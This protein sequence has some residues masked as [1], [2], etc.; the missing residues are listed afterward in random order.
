MWHSGLLPESL[1][2][3]LSIRHRLIGAH[4]SI[5]ARSSKQH[6]RE[7]AT[8][9][10][11]VILSLTSHGDRIKSAHIAIETL[12]RQT[13]A[14]ERVILWISDRHSISGL[15]SPL[16]RQMRRGLDVRLV[17]DIGPY[18]K[19]IYALRKFPEYAIVTVDDDSVYAADLIE[20]LHDAFTTQPDCVHCHRARAMLF[21]ENGYLK[22]YRE[23]RLIGDGN[24]APSHMIFPTGVGGVLY[25]PGALHPEVFNQKI[26]RTICPTADDVWLKA[27]TL[28]N[29]VKSK[30]MIGPHREFPLV[31]GTH[32][33]GLW[34]INIYAGRND[35][36]I[37][38]VFSHYDLLKRLRD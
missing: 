13:A 19:I 32:T 24:D 18:T 21:D 29:G 23:W 28:L 8:K 10:A 15:P 26:F 2:R 33:S 25:P 6:A 34:H 27:M 30:R 14:A 35:P 38:A 20:R 11:P 1:A 16:Q 17:P 37:E 9:Q 3:S 22:P 36:Q 12:L 5:V 7:F 4:L 31:P